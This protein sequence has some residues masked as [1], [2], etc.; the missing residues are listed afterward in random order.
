MGGGR[1]LLSAFC[2]MPQ[3]MTYS[4]AVHW[5][6]N[7]LSPQSNWSAL[8]LAETSPWPVSATGTI[9]DEP[10]VTVDSSCSPKFDARRSLP[11]SL[12]VHFAAWFLSRRLRP[13]FTRLDTAG[14]W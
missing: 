6:V 4:I 3:Q 7:S 1:Q 5:W 12:D 11:L 8:V 14:L 10:P 13:P 2:P 9:S